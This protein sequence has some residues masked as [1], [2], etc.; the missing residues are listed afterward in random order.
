MTVDERSLIA[1]DPLRS[2]AADRIVRL[3][4]ATSALRSQLDTQQS[5]SAV[6]LA[7]VLDDVP[8]SYVLPEVRADKRRS[9]LTESIKEFELARHQTRLVLVAM[10][11][12]EGMSIAD[13]ARA[14]G[15][16]RQLASRWVRESGC[17][18]V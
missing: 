5:V 6:V 1:P 12:D 7:A 16:S 3:M 13:V 11:V 2:E 10:A 17:V 4:D 14:W 15:V 18:R 8:V 9:A